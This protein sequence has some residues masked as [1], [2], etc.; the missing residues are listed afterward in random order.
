MDAVNY[1]N[2]RQQLKKYMKN[3]NDNNEPLIVTTK[4]SEDDVVVLSKSDYDSMME[5]MAV[6]SN[7]YLMDKINSGD[8]QFAA[9][10][11]K[12]HKLFEVNNENTVD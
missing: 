3:V 8:E 12:E 5:T 7:K 4:N 10:K 2:F 9:G 6:L 11:G 1:S